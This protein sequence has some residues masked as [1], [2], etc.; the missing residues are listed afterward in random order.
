[1]DAVAAV[2]AL[3]LVPRVAQRTSAPAGEAIAVDPVDRLRQRWR[4][5]SVEAGWSWPDDWRCAE[6]DAVT[7]QLVSPSGQLLPAC[8]RLGRARAAA[9]GVWLD[10]TLEDIAALLVAAR[11][12]RAATVPPAEVLIRTVALAWADEGAAQFRRICVEDPSTGLTTLPYLRTRLGEIYREAARSGDRVCTTHA[13]I[14]VT[15]GVRQQPQRGRLLRGMALGEC[16]RSVFSGGETLATAGVERAL[17]LV[18]RTPL[19][20]TMV[21]AVQ[22]ELTRLDIADAT[23]RAWIER[24]PDALPAALDLVTDLSR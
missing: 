13:L 24:L 10:E 14:V 5:A 21:Q 15:T 17:G 4:Q 9:A 7:E 22:R 2:D 8:V 11:G 23:P 3:S 19:L 1:M 6:V 12:V 18:A 20:P 16:L